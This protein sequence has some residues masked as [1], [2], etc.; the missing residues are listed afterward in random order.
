MRIVVN[1]LTRMQHGYICVAGID[2]ASGKH[3]RPQPEDD[4]W[5]RPHTLRWGG[6]FDIGAMVDLGRASYIGCAPEVEDYRVRPTHARREADLTPTAFWELL[7]RIS[8]ARLTEIFGADLHRQADTFA[9]DEGKGMA[10]LGCLLLS[11]PPVLRVTSPRELR[12]SFNTAPHTPS[13]K[14]TDMRLYAGEPATVRR[15][16]VQSISAR[17][18][19]D[20]PVILSLGLGRPWQ[21]AGDDAPRHWLQVNNIHLEDD[22]LWQERSLPD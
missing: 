4:R 14:V 3:V 8:C 12:L 13:I 17:M 10:S 22:P 1:H 19:R 15:E 6:P 20:V 9:V 18:A 7:M 11:R 21:K 5:R 2:P 16:I